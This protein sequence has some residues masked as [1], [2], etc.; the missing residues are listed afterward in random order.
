LRTLA[1]QVTGHSKVLA[2]EEAAR[3]YE[4]AL[5]ALDSSQ[6][7]DLHA[8]YELLLAR[9]QALARGG[10]TREAK[11]AFVSA[12]DLARTSRSFADFARAVLGYGGLFPW[13]RAGSDAR[14]VPLLEEALD[15]L[16]DR[17]P[18][19]RVRLLAR[20]A[21]ALRDEPSLEP[22]SSLSLEA[23]E[24]AREL[25]EP[26]VLG[27]ALA[28]HFTATMGPEIEQL[29]PILDEL[30]QVAAGA[31]DVERAVDATWLRRIVAFSLGDVV[32]VERAAAE[33]RAFA[34]ELR[35]P[36]QLW[37]DA[38]M[39]STWAL[40]RGDLEVAE[41]T[42]EEALRLGEQAQSWDAGFSYRITLFFVRREQAR[43]DEAAQLVRETVDTYRGYRSLRCLL[44]LLECELGH[45]DAAQLVFEQ[46]AA[47]DFAALPRDSEWIFCLC[48][49]S[50]VCVHLRDA[51]RAAVLYRLLLPHAHLN[52][53]AAGEVAIGSV[54]RYLGLLAT[55]LERW[56]DALSHFEV[57]L[58][59][60]ERMGARPWLART[61]DDYARMLFVHGEPGDAERAQRLLDEALD[62]YRELGMEGALANAGAE[63]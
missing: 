62:T 15:R 10:S 49:L 22:R 29:T 23:V 34:E 42:A 61:Q 31:G 8:R 16:G 46:L 44:A 11:E 51:G 54:A 4:L 9:G 35:Q 59:M 6:S 47:D 45:P 40:F 27:Y 5:Q 50:E 2:Y 28:S 20:L 52:A 33:H 18:A 60:N 58:E 57:A 24:I 17:E 53:L 26:S 19:L 38:V 36:S 1:V 39:R 37:Y 55:T 3:L 56:D 43:L 12:A 21:G 30:G 14:L 7:V 48:I 32:E 63:R 13:L 25:G 41:R